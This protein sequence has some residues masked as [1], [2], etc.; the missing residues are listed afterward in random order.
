MEIT[1]IFVSEDIAHVFAAG[2]VFSWVEFVVFAIL[3]PF[4]EV[5]VDLIRRKL[6]LPVGRLV[7]WVKEQDE[8]NKK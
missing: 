3:D 5:I 8:V 7:A 1:D 2:I 4:F 6:G